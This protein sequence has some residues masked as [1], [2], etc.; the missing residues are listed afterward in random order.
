MQRIQ[1]QAGQERGEKGLWVCDGRRGGSFDG[2]KICPHAG[3][4]GVIVLWIEEYMSTHRHVE[5][6]RDEIV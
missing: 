5:R 4:L 1:P 2:T 6:E 3:T